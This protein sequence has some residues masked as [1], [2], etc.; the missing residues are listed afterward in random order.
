MDH[1]DLP[2]AQIDEKVFLVDLYHLLSLGLEE[3]CVIES[4]EM[5]HLTSKCVY[6]GES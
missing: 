5:R 2:S 1:P 6:T 3:M 4:S